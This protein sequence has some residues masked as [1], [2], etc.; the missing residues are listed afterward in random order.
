MAGDHDLGEAIQERREA[1][2]AAARDAMLQGLPSSEKAQRARAEEYDAEQ[3]K[4]KPRLG[5]KMEE[6]VEHVTETWPAEKVNRTILEEEWFKSGEN[7]LL[8]MDAYSK[9]IDLMLKTRKANQTMQHDHE[10]MV[11]EKE[12]MKQKTRCIDLEVN[13]ADAESAA[14]IRILDQRLQTEKERTAVVRQAEHDAAMKVADA[15]IAADTEARK[16]AQEARFRRSRTSPVITTVDRNTVL[17][18]VFHEDMAAKCGVQGCGLYVNALKNKIAGEEPYMPGN[19]DKLIVVCNAHA[20]QSPWFVEVLLDGSVIDTWLFRHGL[21]TVEKCA[22]CGNCPVRPW[23]AH[24]CHCKSRAHGGD[25]DLANR[26][27]GSATCNSQQSTQPLNAFRA[28]LMAGEVLLDSKYPAERITDIAHVVRTCDKVA[29]TT[30]CLTR[31]R[32]KLCA[33]RQTKLAFCE[34]QSP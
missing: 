7:L 6:L 33:A 30:D 31:V 10:R 23:D 20:K 8:C 27:V 24:D 28:R 4:K 34:K 11:M 22:I 1:L 12:S 3:V 9:Y 5:V 26:V 16:V 14:R 13:R 25:N 2:P 18:R 17:A 21:S 19:T 15:K 29:I 32:N